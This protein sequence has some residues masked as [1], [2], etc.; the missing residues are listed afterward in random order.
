MTEKEIRPYGSWTSPI[1]A[2]DAA[3]GSNRPGQIMVSQ[4][5]VYWSESRP[6]EQ[7]RVAVMRRSQ[8]GEVEEVTPSDFN[9]RTRVHEY[10]GG[11]YFADG[12]TLYASHFV[13]Q[14][15][16]KIEPGKEPVAI[17]SEPEIPA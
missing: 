10:G 8:T 16:Y 6:K 13:D 17:T 2:E 12:E 11:A 5:I 15:L 7:G 1:S 3:A 14:R 4:G 9:C